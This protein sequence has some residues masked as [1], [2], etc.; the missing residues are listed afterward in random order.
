MKA[1]AVI[2]ARGGSKRIPG[3]NIKDFLGKPVIAYAIE[4]ALASGL[5]DEVMVS[6]DSSEIAETARRFGASV[7]FV[8][9]EKNSDDHATTFAV[10]EEVYRNYMEKG[11]TIE[12]ICCIYPCTPL[13]PADSLQEGFLK[14]T[15]NDF[16]SVYPLWLI[17]HQFSGH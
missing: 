1:V 7:P 14:L 12:T 3:K 9:S 10:I 8:R 16:D 4:K 15:E 6:T 13:F 17:R 2:P 5:F 11:I